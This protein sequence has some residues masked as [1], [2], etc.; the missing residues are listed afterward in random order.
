[1]VDPDGARQLRA[2]HA[3]TRLLR[4]TSL[5][6]DA[7]LSHICAL[8][9]P[10]MQFPDDTSARIRFGAFEHA[11]AGF[12][13]VQTRLARELE[14]TDGERGVLE[15]GYRSPHPDA[16]EGL[17]VVFGVVQQ[18]NGFVSVDSEP[19]EGAQFHIHIPARYS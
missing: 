11:T 4:N 9:P 3:T 7:L 14:T 6:L 2:L 15:V 17:A 10:A 18:C 5:S 8:L 13:E 1:M 19:G 12:S 16:Q